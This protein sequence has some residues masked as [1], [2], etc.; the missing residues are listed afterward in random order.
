V[1]GFEGVLCE[2]DRITP[3]TV[4]APEGVPPAFQTLVERKIAKA[5]ARVVKAQAGERPGAVHRLL[6]AANLQLRAIGRKAAK[7]AQSR[8]SRPG[9]LSDACRDA[10]RRHLA[11][12]QDGLLGLRTR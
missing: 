6:G 1:G 3:A 9:L 5:R 10:I 4:C 11:G 8:R 7:L 2:L 12:V